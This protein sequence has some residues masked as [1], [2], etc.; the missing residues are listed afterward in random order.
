[1]TVADLVS[2]IPF[3]EPVALVELTG[4]ELLDAF[5]QMS[6]AVVDFGEDGW[7][8]GHVSGARIV[9][10][11]DT[12]E[13]VEATVDGDP[14][15]P[16]ALYTVAMAEYLLH[17]DHEFPAVEERHR[18]GEF[19]IQHEVLAAYA[20]EYGIDP[21]VEGRIERRSRTPSEQSD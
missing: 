2:V 1:V 8:H 7:W 13:L 5:R 6:S 9:W 14:V 10:D 11:D 17:S 19:G 4:A 18:A 20:R 12:A 21:A 16:D 15:D 3:E